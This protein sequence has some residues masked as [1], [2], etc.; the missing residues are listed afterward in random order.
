MTQSVT[1][2]GDMESYKLATALSDSD[3]LMK[4]A[5]RLPCTSPLGFGIK[6]CAAAQKF[7]DLSLKDFTVQR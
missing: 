6:D 5:T 2:D 1:A 4:F 7:I 3:G